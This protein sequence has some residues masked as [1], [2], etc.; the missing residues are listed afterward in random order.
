MADDPGA[1]LDQLL[2][3]RCER[4][5]R[6]RLRRRKRAQKVPEVVRERMKLQTN[7]VCVE[8]ATR[9]PRPFDR[10][11]AF[12]DL[13]LRGTT[14]VVKG[15]HVLAHDRQVRDDK[16]NPGQEFTRMPLYFGNHASRTGPTLL[17]RNENSGITAGRSAVGVRPV[18]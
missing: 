6:N 3:Q 14:F 16:G 9:K 13:L 18:V 15:D 1:D 4:P 11:L 8:C 10:T 2:T 17:L 7:G 12:L 5:T